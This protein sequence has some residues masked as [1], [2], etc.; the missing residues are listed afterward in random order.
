MISIKLVLIPTDFSEYSKA[1]LPYAVDIS[2][3]YGA[4]L[5]ILHIFDEELL[6]PIFFE[7]G[8]TAKEY[9][10]RL[11]NRF[12]AAVEDFLSGVNTDGIEL[13]AELGNGTPFVEII[14]FAKENGAD[15]IVMG[16]HGRTGIAHTLLGSV[17]EKVVRKSPCPVMVIRHPEFKFEMP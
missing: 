11:Q 16:T 17:T 15:I 4:K 7:T 8:K 3:K 13:E 1:A 9:F 12:E 10:E 6:S 14:R 5:V 2:R